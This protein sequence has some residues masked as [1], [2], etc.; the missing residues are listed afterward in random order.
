MWK[1][2]RNDVAKQIRENDKNKTVFP[3]DCFYHIPKLMMIKSMKCSL[4]LSLTH[5]ILY[6]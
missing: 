2:K 1:Y 3:F 6:A 4:M 5:T